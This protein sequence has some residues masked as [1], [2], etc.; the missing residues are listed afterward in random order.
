MDLNI[1]A[2]AF[3]NQNHRLRPPPDIPFFHPF[4]KR[5]D[6]NVAPGPRIP[7][8]L[9]AEDI[10]RSHPAQTRQNAHRFPGTVSY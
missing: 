3:L 4:H 1:G 2:D 5:R 9:G 7:F 10:G 6:I 8:H